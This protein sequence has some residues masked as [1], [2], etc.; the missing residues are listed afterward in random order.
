MSEITLI[1]KPYL[2]NSSIQ[3]LLLVTSPP[4]EMPTWSTFLP[5]I[6]LILLNILKMKY[7]MPTQH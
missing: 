2:A 1:K 4:L 7:I 5:Q 6:T 3:C